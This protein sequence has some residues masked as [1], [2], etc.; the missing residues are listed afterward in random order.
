M[1]V[2]GNDDIEGRHPL[3]EALKLDWSAHCETRIT[4]YRLVMPGDWIKHNGES[5]PVSGG[6]RVE[7]G[8]RDG[9]RFEQAAS[10]LIWEH[11]GHKADIIAYR[12]IE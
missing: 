4:Q 6:T 12:V 3:S 5:Q 8:L 7:I 10:V 1:I 2:K 9:T 11:L